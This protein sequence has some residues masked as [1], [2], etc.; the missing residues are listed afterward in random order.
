MPGACESLVSIVDG[1]KTA[2]LEDGQ[3]DERNRTHEAYIDPRVPL[4]DLHIMYP[5]CF[6]LRGK[7]FRD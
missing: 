4:E 3:I 1:S 7:Q 2:Q 5:E 6:E